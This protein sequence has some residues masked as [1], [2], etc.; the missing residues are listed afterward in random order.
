[1]GSQ[2][3]HLPSSANAYPGCVSN[4]ALRSMA[5]KY[6]K[7]YRAARSELEQPDYA[8][9]EQ[10]R[11]LPNY[12]GYVSKNDRTC[13][14]R[15]ASNVG[16]VVFGQRGPMRVVS[17]RSR[18]PFPCNLSAGHASIC[19]GDDAVMTSHS[20]DPDTGATVVER[21]SCTD[22]IRLLWL[23]PAVAATPRQT[24]KANASHLRATEPCVSW[25]DTGEQTCF[26][27]TGKEP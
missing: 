16:A 18:L 14:N 20:A 26:A 5:D 4:R 2:P 10:G 7:Q 21:S 24:T 11:I 1:M 6:S 3:T 15:T 12:K 19:S 27:G 17:V 25:A 22:R 23:S 13:W 8:G 9:I